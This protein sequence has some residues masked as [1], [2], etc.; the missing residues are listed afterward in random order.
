MDEFLSEWEG[1]F[2]A[3]LQSIGE[4]DDPTPALRELN[5]TLTPDS[6]RLQAAYL[7][8]ARE[9]EDAYDRIVE[10]G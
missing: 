3:M 7:K 2:D 4:G 10:H 6:L 8:S 5:R 9:R 1:R